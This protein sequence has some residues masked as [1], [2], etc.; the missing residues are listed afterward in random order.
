MLQSNLGHFR[1]KRH[2]QYSTAL[3]PAMNSA[4]Q[5]VTEQT[6]K[7]L[8][9]LLLVILKPTSPSPPCPEQASDRLYTKNTPPKNLT[10]QNQTKK[11]PLKY[12]KVC[13]AASAFK[14]Y[15]TRKTWQSKFPK[16]QEPANK[17]RTQVKVLQ[18]YSISKMQL[19]SAK[20]CVH[21]FK[22][23]DTAHC[24]QY[25]RNT[26]FQRTAIYI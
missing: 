19:F 8:N 23:Q 6:C 10:G 17:P 13:Q 21:F 15:S 16:L 4:T 18:C 7:E 24:S 20:K 11:K 25:F 14:L 2:C 5:R 1:P 3:P 26:V 9:S 12:I 22:T